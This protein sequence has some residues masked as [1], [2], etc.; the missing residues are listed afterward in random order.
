[1]S[2]G[3]NPRPLSAVLSELI[4]LRGLARVHGENQLAEIWEQA[5]GPAIAGKTRIRGLKRGV[6]EVAVSNTPL[7]GE[8][9]SFHRTSLLEV[10]QKENPDL[11]I[12]NLKFHLNGNL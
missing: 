3:H 5:A 7:L 8:L 10:L 12:R 9:V 6:F 1:M 4:A 11:Q 2:T